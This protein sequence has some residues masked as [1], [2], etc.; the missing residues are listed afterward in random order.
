MGW[1]YLYN[2]DEDA[3]IMGIRFNIV[4]NT[5]HYINSSI[6]FDT[7]SIVDYADYLN[8][9]VDG[10][11][12]KNTAANYV[13]AAP[14]NTAIKQSLANYKVNGLTSFDSFDDAVALADKCGTV[15]ELG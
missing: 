6:C 7:V 14:A 12:S 9:E 4:A 15:V 1:S 2:A 8:G 3:Y 13:T 5:D 11:T 10:A